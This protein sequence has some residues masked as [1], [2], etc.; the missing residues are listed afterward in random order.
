MFLP[1]LLVSDSQEKRTDVG[2]QFFHPDECA[3]SDLNG[4]Y[5]SL[6]YP[7]PYGANGNVEVL[8]SLRY[9]KKWVILNQ[10]IVH[11]S[12]PFRVVFIHT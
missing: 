4:G 6:F 8:S 7:G 10:M 5:P 2:Q 11:G 9:P 12:N 3:A 1:R